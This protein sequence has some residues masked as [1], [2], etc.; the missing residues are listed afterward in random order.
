MNIISLFKKRV[1][2]IDKDSCSE[3]SVGMSPVNPFLGDV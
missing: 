1:R 2:Y 3:T